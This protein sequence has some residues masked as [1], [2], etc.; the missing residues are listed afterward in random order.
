MATHTLV[1][2]VTPD[3]LDAIATGLPAYRVA[4]FIRMFNK[5]AHRPAAVEL[6]RFIL[7]GLPTWATEEFCAAHVP[8]GFYPQYNPPYYRTDTEQVAACLFVRWDKP[9]YPLTD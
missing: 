1:R 8:P 9:W 7:D 2:F 4:C 3:E 5:A 6:R